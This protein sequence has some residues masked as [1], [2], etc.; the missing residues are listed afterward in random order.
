MVAGT[1]AVR[2]SGWCRVFRP[3]PGATLRLVC[4][5]Q[6]G[7]AASAFH[8]WP[9]RLPDT[10]EVVAVQYAGRQDRGDEEPVSD[11]ATL[12]DLVARE[13]QPLLDRP[14][15]FF[16]HSL[17]ATIAFEVARR[18]R[19][20]FPSP[21]T[22]LV[23]AARKPPAECGRGSRDRAGVRSDEDLRRY[24]TRVGGRAPLVLANEELW[25]ATV[26]ALRGDLLMADTYTYTGG[27]PL[28]CPITVVAAA[29]D[30]GCG[31]AEMRGWS[32]YTIGALDEHLVPG[33]HFFLNAPP[34]ELFTVLAD[35]LGTNGRA[36]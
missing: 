26:P 13:V 18:L 27:V 23:V 16:G 1:P 11:V 29:D 31:L 33:D 17:G 6:A 32:G 9:D 30:R 22:R 10:V 3:R 2:R 25:Q 20:R 15:A 12:A 24:L 5:P 28:T 19:P 35:V 4:F 34:A 7:G 8:D 21:L 14:V 36:E